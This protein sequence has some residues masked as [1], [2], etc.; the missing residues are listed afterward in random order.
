MFFV[1]VILSILCGVSSRTNKAARVASIRC[2][3]THQDC[4]GPRIKG[5]CPAV[6]QDE[7]FNLRCID[8]YISC[9][10]PQ[11]IKRCRKNRR[12]RRACPESCGIC[13]QNYNETLLE[14][15]ANSL[16]FTISMYV[17]IGSKSSAI[18]RT[19]KTL[20]P[21]N[22][23][24]TRNFVV[25]EIG[26]K[27][28]EALVLTPPPAA[29]RTLRSPSLWKMRRIVLSLLPQ[30]IFVMAWMTSGLRLLSSVK[31]SLVVSEL[32]IKAH[33]SRQI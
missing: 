10:S 23:S 3:P 16:N 9:D 15:T 22:Q 12:V 13:T 18:T 30:W 17:E 2:S 29:S 5:I 7:P 28:K 14:D 21:L 26:F 33:T 32:V 24:N 11:W 19:H 6:C 8:L 31:R 27:Q 4:H 1:F 25:F 20:K